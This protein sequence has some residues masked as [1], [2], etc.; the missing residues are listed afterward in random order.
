MCTKTILVILL[1]LA[2][3]APFASAQLKVTPENPAGAIA[4]SDSFPGVPDTVAGFFLRYLP[5]ARSLGAHH[6][7]PVTI[8]LAVSALETGY[9]CNGSS[10][11]QHC[12][13]L[14]NIKRW[15][16]ADPVCCQEVWEDGPAAEETYACFRRYERPEDSFLN[17]CRLMHHPRFK[18]L[19][20]LPIW[21]YRAWAEGLQAAGYATDR[22]YA[23]KLISIIERY[24]LWRFDPIPRPHPYKKVKKD[25][26]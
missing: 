17:F 13:N 2:C 24:Q 4:Q 11:I 3:W 21:K 12:F 18:S 1:P 7:V 5:V 14:F 10:V 22:H 20:Y 26:K 19:T 6:H 23:F 15:S 25:R 16:G 9:G 8:Q